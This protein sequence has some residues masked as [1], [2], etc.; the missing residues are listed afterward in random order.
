MVEDALSR[1]S[2]GSVTY[3]VDGKKELVKRFIGLLICV[4][5]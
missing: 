1:V 2:M 5:E 3:V 4:F